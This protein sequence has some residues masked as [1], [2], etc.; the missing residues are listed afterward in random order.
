MIMAKVGGAELVW[1]I[2]LVGIGLLLLRSG[3][4]LLGK[5]EGLEE[6][7]LHIVESS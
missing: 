5:G 6:M 4:A 2:C 1:Q 7:V 3:S